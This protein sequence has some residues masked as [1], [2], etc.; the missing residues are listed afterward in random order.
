MRTRLVLV[1]T[2]GTCGG[3]F[4]ASGNS[5]CR[6]G[7]EVDATGLRELALR[8][9]P[10]QVRILGTADKRVRVRCELGVDQNPSQTKINWSGSVSS[11]RLT[12]EGPIGGNQKYRLEVPKQSDLIL[13]VKAGDVSVR[14]V[15]GNKDV[16]MMAGD[17]KIEVGQPGDYAE[18]DTAVRA[19]DLHA[20]PFNQKRGGLFRSFKR[21]NSQGKYKLHATLGAGNL[22]LE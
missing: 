16:E 10:G 18:I 1:A 7:L 3:L 17:L 11:A 6:D 5:T 9:S 20:L 2:L 13:R 22:T 15:E 8:I 4:G 12:I 14:G 19:G 21:H